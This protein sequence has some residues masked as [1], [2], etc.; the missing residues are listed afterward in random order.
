VD[1]RWHARHPD[2]DRARRWQ[3]KNTPKLAGVPWDLAQEEF[4]AKGAVVL[5]GL[6]EVAI[7]R[8]QDEM[9]RHVAMTTGESGG[10]PRVIGQD[11]MGGRPP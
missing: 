9:R 7:H 4:G 1:Q 6:V 10:L 3:Q 8:A 2:Y 5:E 11:E